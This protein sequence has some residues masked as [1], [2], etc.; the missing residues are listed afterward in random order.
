MPA[1]DYLKAHATIDGP[2]F[3][4]AGKAAEPQQPTSEALGPGVYNVIQPL[5]AAPAFTMLGKG[6][7]AS[8]LDSPGE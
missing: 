1:G 3:T 4:I 8:R 5:P 6:A 2:A 7:Q